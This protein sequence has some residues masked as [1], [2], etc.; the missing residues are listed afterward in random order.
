MAQ[1]ATRNALWM[2]A[3]IQLLVLRLPLLRGVGVV[4]GIVTDSALVPLPAVT[5]NVLQTG[6]AIQTGESGRFRITQLQSGR[7]M[8]IV[9]RLGFEALS[10]IVEVRENDTLRLALTMYPVAVALDT[11]RVMATAGVDRLAGFEDR[12]KHEIG[13]K[14]ISR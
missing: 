6:T 8:L 10:A 14:Y 2:A 4:D 7:H 13:G 9:R 11:T 5:V 1:L 12:R 3:A